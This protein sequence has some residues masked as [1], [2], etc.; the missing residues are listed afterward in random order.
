MRGNFRYLSAYVKSTPR[1]SS[2]AEPIWRSY[3]STAAP[4]LELYMLL[5]VLSCAFLAACLAAPFITLAKSLF[6]NLHLYHMPISSSLTGWHS[7]ATPYHGSF[8]PTHSALKLVVLHNSPVE[9]EGFTLALFSTP[10]KLAVDSVGRVLVVRDDDFMNLLALAGELR[11]LPDAGNFRNTWVVAQPVTSRPIE[12]ILVPASP[13]D[14][15][16]N[17]PGY[18][19][20]SVQGY[21]GVKTQLRRRVGDIQDLPSLLTHIVSLVLEAREGGGGPRDLGMINRVK[22]ILGDVF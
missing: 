17:R 13:G 16:G 12:R 11:E 20:T 14:G 2:K 6:A 4:Q 15:S 21:D 7:R 18:R 5:K 19:E 1:L 22:A 9:P 10:A 3:G 8:T